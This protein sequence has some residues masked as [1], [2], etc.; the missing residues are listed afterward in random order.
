M[1]YVVCK[2]QWRKDVDTVDICLTP[3]CAFALFSAMAHSTT[4]KLKV[5]QLQTCRHL[6]IV[7]LLPYEMAVN[8][9][10]LLNTSTLYLNILA[11]IL[12]NI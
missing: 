7:S 10:I 11:C 9:A 5:W 6:C 2:C 4:A 1:F 8:V 12:K 3:Y